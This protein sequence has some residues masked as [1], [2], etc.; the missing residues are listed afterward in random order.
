MRTALISASIAAIVAAAVSLPLRSPDD[1]VL[2]SATVVIGSLLAGLCAGA[3]WRTLGDRPYRW[4]AF[5][6]SMAAGFTVIAA[7]SLV[8]NTQ[9]EHL[10]SFVIPLAAIVV[11][12]TGGLLPLF[13]RVAVAQTQWIAPGAVVIALAV[14]FGLVGLG[15]AD[16]GRLSLPDR[17]EILTPGLVSNATAEPSIGRN[18][19]AAP[20]PTATAAAKSSASPASGG[21]IPG[22]LTYI[23]VDGSEATFTVTEQLVRLPLPNDAVM[24]TTALSGWA[25]IDDGRSVIEIDL[26]TLSSDQDFR[27]RYVRGRMFPSHRI[28]TFTVDDFAWISEDFLV[29]SSAGETVTGQVSGSLSIRDVVVP[30]TFDVE[31][32]NDG[33]VVYI[34][35]RTT[36]TWDQLQIPKPSARPVV[37]V[38]DEVRVEVLLRAEPR[39][40]SGG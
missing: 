39:P 28:A 21:G 19:A 7:V 23:V 11:V 10:V 15:D 20:Q 4:R 3:L 13:G 5:A 38:E 12:V 34:L 35:G 9:V 37:S 30:L 2:N 25:S 26:H 31:A 32:R 27:D 14:G 29:G 40:D 16:S 18:A 22:G 6:V 8:A 24:R 33:V 1:A 17:P 36:F